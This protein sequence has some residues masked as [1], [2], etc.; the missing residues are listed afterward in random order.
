MTLEHATSPTL[1]WVP[2]AP[3]IAYEHLGAGT[4]VVFLHGVGGNRTNWRDQLGPVGHSFHAIAW[5]A[6]GY[7]DSDDVPGDW[8]FA[9]YADDLI[10]LLDH[11][12]ADCAHIVGL[13]MGGRIAQDFYTRYPERVRSLALCDTFARLGESIDRASFMRQRRDPLAAGQQPSDIAP[14]L[15][16]SLLGTR[17]K[18][19]HRERLIASLSALRRESYLRTLEVLARHELEL[20]PE[21]IA[22]P[23]LLV[24]GG[25]DRLTPPEIGRQLRA[26]IPHS[27]LCIVEGAGHLVN[28]EHPAA[29][30]QSLL[31]FLRGLSRVA[32][33]PAD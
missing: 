6:R 27:E 29:F 20:E 7:G 25:D 14:A 26:R 8:E 13:S 1:D 31:H 2:S 3:R 19:E 23:T 22:V 11:L 30:N 17:A 28:I 15:A 12:E 4:P 9:A 21:R 18:P 16:E 32:A 10:R 33:R 5:D 24:F